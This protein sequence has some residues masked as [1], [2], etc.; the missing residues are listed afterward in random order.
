M[1]KNLFLEAFKVKSFFIAILNA[2]IRKKKD[3]RRASI[4]T[5]KQ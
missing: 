5:E 3:C 2:I 4:I 1:L